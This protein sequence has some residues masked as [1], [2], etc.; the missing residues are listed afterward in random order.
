MKNVQIHV[1]RSAHM[2]M[3]ERLRFA[4]KDLGKRRMMTAFNVAAV[5]IAVV[6]LL[7]P[8]FYGLS[9]YRYQQS[10]LD[11]SLPTLI[12]ASCPD[13]S[14]ERLRFTNER[15]GCIAGLADA[16]LAF[17]KVELN[18]KLS[19]DSRS[20][21]DVPVEGTIPDDPA[22]SASRLVWGRPVKGGVAHEIVIS[23]N[24]FKKVGGSL[25]TT[26]PTPSSI[27]LQVSRTVSGQS[28]SHTLPLEIVGVFGYQTADKIYAPLELV[29]Q[30]DQWCSNKIT[31]IGDPSQR[32]DVT[33]PHCF[34]YVPREYRQRVEDEAKQLNVALQLEGE[35]TVYDASED[36]WA[37]VEANDGDV[38]LA[39]VKEAVEA[40]G[41][42]AYP[43]RTLEWAAPGRTYTV[44]A[45]SPDD[46][47][48]RNTSTQHAPGFGEAVSKG[49]DA[50]Q[51]HFPPE[52]VKIVGEFDAPGRG[53]FY[54]LPETLEWLAFDYAH[55]F[56]VRR[57]AITETRDVGTALRWESEKP[58]SVTPDQ[59]LCW[60]IYDVREPQGSAGTGQTSRKEPHGPAATILGS[61]EAIGIERPQVAS[62][63]AP[64]DTLISQLK[65]T[66]PEAGAGAV[67]D[68]SVRVA[69]LENTAVFVSTRVIPDELFDLLSSDHSK[70]GGWEI[71]QARCIRIGMSTGGTTDADL[72]VDG[73]KV[74]VVATLPGSSLL[75]LLPESSRMWLCP[76]AQKSGLACWGDWRRSEE[77][78]KFGADQRELT[79]L[80]HAAL[81]TVYSRFCERD[82]VPSRSPLTGDNRKFTLTE[83]YT[84]SVGATSGGQRL[85]SV[86]ATPMAAGMLP[87][88]ECSSAVLL[89]GPRDAT[90][91]AGGYRQNVRLQH[92]N[93]LPAD[94]AVL[95]EPTFRRLSFEAAKSAG[96]L[97]T[98]GS[99]NAAIH[100]PILRYEKAMQELA[101]IGFRMSPL[102]PIR[103]QSLLK[104]RVTDT[105]QNNG[106]VGQ[107][108]VR[109]LAMTK[110][111]FAAL[112]PALPTAAE[113]SGATVLQ[114]SS[115]SDPQRFEAELLQGRWLSGDSRNE[116]ILPASKAENVIHGRDLRGC[117]GAI[118]DVQF[119]RDKRVAASEPALTLPLKVVGIVQSE[120][121]VV[122][123]DLLRDIALWSD[124][125]IVFNDT[126]MTFETPSAIYVR[127]GHVRCNVHATDVDSVE[128][129]VTRLQGMGYRT[130]DSLADQQGLRRLGQALSFVVGVF[131][132]GCLL[133]AGKMIIVTTM[134]NVHTKRWE[135]G[136]LKAHGMRTSTI[137]SIFAL[138]GAII[139]AAAFAIGGGLVVVLEPVLR[140]WIGASFKIPMHA[141]VSGSLCSFDSAWLLATALA[142]A[143]LLST[144]GVML[145]ATRAAAKLPVETLQRRE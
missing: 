53:D 2:R 108:L 140:N 104:F 63:E 3:A 49:T 48:W 58:S 82:L 120:S 99:S 130:E 23:E 51:A 40:V 64:V 123:L 106:R 145:P 56:L 33:Y 118:V 125:K 77:I 20:S 27:F 10:V 59:P 90:I 138:Q 70:A 38:S 17:A 36:V 50:R 128:P 141:V 84:L 96:E 95:D 112:V 79:Y 110:P 28:Q 18:V 11:D 97:S 86:C 67:F 29:Q 8:A 41:G 34:A 31:S 45:L 103:E 89:N 102:V 92:S 43:V 111:T 81:P 42:E 83:V 88:S 91:E 57:D 22:L 5:L 113:L 139:G 109:V 85:A 71:C 73:R 94:I 47:R 87:K 55:C 131:A 115:P 132:L 7:I 1:Q 127:R 78:R 119:R 74:H 80:R 129:L 117:V 54:C 24:F 122:P 35:V 12:V 142:V 66:W 44:V 133:I 93:R 98:G 16:R 61:D 37:A 105:Q 121:A 107:N 25:G 9:I 137:L 114:A 60:A 39:A 6:Y 15:I 72:W 76:T 4:M 19:L 14:D 126:K 62:M 75:L 135:I 30:L 69:P 52:L 46:P 124:G 13:V 136:I 116:I 101:V 144:L 32:P 65:S 21:I 100:F 68:G 26:G 134:M 143:L